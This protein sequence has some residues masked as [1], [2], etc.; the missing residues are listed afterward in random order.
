MIKLSD[1]LMKNIKN[2]VGCYAL[3]TYNGKVEATW[4]SKY[5]IENKDSYWFLES[6][7]EAIKITKVAGDIDLFCKEY[8]N[9]SV[10]LI[11]DIDKENFINN[12]IKPLIKNGWLYE[13]EAPQVCPYLPKEVDDIKIISESECLD[14]LIS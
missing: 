8:V 2:E 1:F 9:N 10:I 7:C 4:F 13:I 14:F 12:F 6:P 5:Y 3:V 11:D